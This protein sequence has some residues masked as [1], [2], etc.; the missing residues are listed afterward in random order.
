MK[1]SDGIILGSPVHYAGISGTMKS[2]MDRPFYV[3]RSNGGLF[4]HKLGTAVV[5]V[6]RTGVGVIIFYFILTNFFI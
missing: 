6:R 5:A 2:F 3:A 1:K 4:R